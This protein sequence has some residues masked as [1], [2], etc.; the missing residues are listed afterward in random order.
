MRILAISLACAATIFVAQPVFA[1]PIS[2]IVA[3]V[4]GDMITS[5][6]LEKAVEPELAAQQIDP[7]KN[8]QLAE[9][10]RQGI[11]DKLINE[12]IVLQQAEKDGIKVD[13]ADVEAALEGVIKES[14]LSREEFFKQ[15]QANGISEKLFRERTRLQLITQRLMGRNVM[16]K[17]VVTEDEINDYYRK[18]MASFASGRARVAMLIYPADANAE[19]WANDIASGKISFADAVRKIS[20]GPNPEEGGDMGFMEL[21]E[22]APG[23]VDVVARMR[24]GE[25]SPLLNTGSVK[26]QVAL[27]DFEE[28]VVPENSEAKPDAD[29]ARRIE[30]ILRRPRIQD[31]LQQYTT[32]LRNKALI[33]IRK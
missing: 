17:V 5:R 11:L 31:R 14:Q 7:K 8:P 9:T 13:D 18:N 6:E 30:E 3:V 28:A 26:A 33:D 21:S 2:R 10:V 20:V 4:N 16:S 22:M 1:A 27:L 32:E 24:K 25:V 12:K 19:K 23:M 15:A 29:T